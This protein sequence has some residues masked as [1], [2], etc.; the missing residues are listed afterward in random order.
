M[1]KTKYDALQSLTSK[2]KSCCTR[3]NYRNWCVSKIWIEKCTCTPCLMP[4]DS[5]YM[6]IHTLH[7]QALRRYIHE[8]KTFLAFCLT[9]THFWFSLVPRPRPFF[10]R[11]FM[12]NII[13]GSRRVKKMGKTW[14]HLSHDTDVSGAVNLRT[15][16]LAYWWKTSPWWRLAHG[17][18]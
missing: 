10:V 13:H 11:L 16:Y 8:A 17:E 9:I 15:K 5:P 12:F 1:A 14:E 3:Y 2:S 7:P 4:P 6:H 18:D